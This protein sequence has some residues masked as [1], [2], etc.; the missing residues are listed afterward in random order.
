MSYA[1]KFLSKVLGTMFKDEMVA[2]L[3]HIIR[4]RTTRTM[5]EIQEV[6]RN[7]FIEIDHETS[8]NVLYKKM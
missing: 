7:V 5:H 3:G 4:N 1:L 6:V 2:L 8:S